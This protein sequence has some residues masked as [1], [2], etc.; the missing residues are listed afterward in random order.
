MLEDSRR[1]TVARKTYPSQQ[2]TR[3]G[4]L[5][6]LLAISSVLPKENVGF[7][8]EQISGSDSAANGLVEMFNANP[9]REAPFAQEL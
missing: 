4:L 9:L 8:G 7:L 1:Q 2:P 3:L 6:Q 5:I